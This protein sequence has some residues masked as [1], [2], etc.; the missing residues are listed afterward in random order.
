VP[1]DALQ[2]ALKVAGDQINVASLR[3]RYAQTVWEL[4]IKSVSFL[5][6]EMQPKA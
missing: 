2:G 1:S 5:T 4:S 3:L 6:F